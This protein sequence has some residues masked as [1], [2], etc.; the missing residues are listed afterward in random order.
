MQRMKMKLSFIQIQVFDS[1]FDFDTKIETKLC[2]DT[3]HCL[4]LTALSFHFIACTAPWSCGFPFLRWGF[5]LFRLLPQNVAD[6]CYWFNNIHSKDIYKEGCTCADKFPTTGFTFLPWGWIISV[7]LNHSPASTYFFIHTI[8]GIIQNLHPFAT[9]SQHLHPSATAFTNNGSTT[10][11]ISWLSAVSPGVWLGSFPC[12]QLLSATVSSVVPSFI[13][14]STYA[15]DLG[16]DTQTKT[17][18]KTATQPQAITQP[19]PQLAQ[20][21]LTSVQRR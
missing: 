9:A 11:G 21:K 5:I 6:H 13:N 10:R 8:G 20:A 4:D 15:S 19:Q 12:P 3:I 2:L 18:P 16:G 17:E 14:S 7:E 1:G